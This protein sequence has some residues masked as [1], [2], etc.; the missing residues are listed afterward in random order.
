[1][2]LDAEP[3]EPAVDDEEEEEVDGEFNDITREYS[4]AGLLNLGN[5]CYL[6]SGVQVLAN[7]DM[8]ALALAAQP[9]EEV[10]RALR[11]NDVSRH[12]RELL[13]WWRRTLNSLLFP[14]SPGALDLRGFVG[15]VMQCNQ[16][17]V[18]FG[19]QDSQE[20]IQTLLMVLDDELRDPFHIPAVLRGITTQPKAPH[21]TR[22][23][24]YLRF[25]DNLYRANLQQDY[26]A[27]CREARLKK[28]LMVTT[29]ATYPRHYRSLVTDF[30]QG[31]YLDLMTCTVCGEVGRRISTW[32]S[33]QLELPTPKQRLELKRRAAAL[34]EPADAAE[35]TVSSATGNKFLDGTLSFMSSAL[36][37]TLS[38]LSIEPGV[39]GPLSLRECLASHCMEETGISRFCNRCEKNQDTTKEMRF[40][41]LPEYLVVSLKRWDHRN[42]YWTSK[43]QSH[44]TF[45]LDW[46]AA[47]FDENEVLDLKEFCYES[48]DLA[49]PETTTYSL[50]GLVVHK[51]S[52]FLGGH[53]ISYVRKGNSWIV[54]NDSILARVSRSVVRDEQAYLLVYRRQTA[55]KP[56]PDIVWYQKRAMSFLFNLEEIGC[57]KLGSRIQTA[58]GEPPFFVSRQ[59]LIKFAYGTEPGL[60]PN[61]H[62]YHF[63]EEDEGTATRSAWEYFCPVTRDDWDFYISTYGGGPAVSLDDFSEAVRAETR[64]AEGSGRAGAGQASARNPACR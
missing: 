40:L 16:T 11:H 43:I 24:A 54:C 35:E 5:T 58:T 8:F 62:V 33:L 38:F 25:I 23:L 18:G 51:G 64:Q 46:S 32:V 31:T 39:D 53:Y 9:G 37:K 41:A 34:E 50:T 14:R 12:R 45:P 6:N 7:C 20:F 44:V 55:A 1:M 26:D 42:G 63:L 61:N 19:Q 2:S 15:A 17:F 22:E 57:Q 49:A 36:A 10:T 3:S 13:E 47:D 27:S 29:G 59:W 56:D 60:I 30:F 52:M 28:K 21:A 4:L 48:S